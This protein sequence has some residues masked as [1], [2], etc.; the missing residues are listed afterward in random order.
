[1]E[2][3]ERYSHAVLAPGFIEPLRWRLAEA[4]PT[5]ASDVFAFAFV[6]WEVRMKFV[7]SDDNLSLNGMVLSRFSAGNHL[8]SAGAF[9]QGCIQF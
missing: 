5:T 4:G 9:S 6:A 7:T 2:D 8:S 1:M 3:I